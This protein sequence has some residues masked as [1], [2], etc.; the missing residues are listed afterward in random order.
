MERKDAFRYIII[1][2]ILLLALQKF[3]N[4]QINQGIILTALALIW[5]KGFDNFIKS[6]FKG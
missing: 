5:T 3:L 6:F 4:H 2:A 1:A